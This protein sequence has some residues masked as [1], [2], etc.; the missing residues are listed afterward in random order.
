MWDFL[1]R[2]E[3]QRSKPDK[4]QKPPTKP[5]RIGFGQVCPRCGRAKLDYNSL[6]N[7]NCPLCGYEL[8]A[9]FT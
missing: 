4:V 6:L 8:N 5:C 9:S 3:D 2:E 1:D 7:L